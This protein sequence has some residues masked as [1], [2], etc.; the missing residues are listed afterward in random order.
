MD[1]VYNDIVNCGAWILSFRR[2]PHW[3]MELGGSIERSQE[4]SNNL[5]NSTLPRYLF[6][7]SYSTEFG[8]KSH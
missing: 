2:L 7:P 4:L 1:P 6:I 5:Y 3:T 8:R